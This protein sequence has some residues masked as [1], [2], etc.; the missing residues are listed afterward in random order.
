LVAKETRARYSREKLF[1]M[2]TN[3]FCVSN[4]YRVFWNRMVGR[5]FVQREEVTE[6]WRKLYHEELHI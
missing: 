4:I 3:M 2:L 6:E 1:E 5:M